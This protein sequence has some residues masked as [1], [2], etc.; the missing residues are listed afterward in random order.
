MKYLIN[1]L[2]S[3]LQRGFIPAIPV[4]YFNG[5]S[6]E[7]LQIASLPKEAAEL[8]PSLEKGFYEVTSNKSC[9]SSNQGF[10]IMFL[11]LQIFKILYVFVELSRRKKLDMDV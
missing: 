8:D 3:L 11:P 6:L 7:P 5:K 10:Q 1:S 9:T 4:G 2:Y